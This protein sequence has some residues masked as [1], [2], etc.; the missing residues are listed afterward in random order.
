MKPTRI[1]LLL[2]ATLGLT[3]SLYALD[4]PTP[5]SPPV[6]NVETRVAES[7]NLQRCIEAALENN[8]DI[9]KAKESIQQQHRIV[10]QSRARFLPS[11]TATAYYQKTD[12]ER[13]QEFQGQSFGSPGT[14]LPRS[15]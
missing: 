12:K 13:I 4:L 10:I 9:K 5:S 15:K 6:E 11:I 8:F 3:S 2:S 7:Y 1:T 14:G